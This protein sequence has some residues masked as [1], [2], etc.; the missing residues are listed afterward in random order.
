MK[1]VLNLAILA[2]T[3]A[4]FSCDSNDPAGTDPEPEIAEVRMLPDSVEIEVGDQMDFSL[5]ALTA[6]GDTVRNANLDV[7]WWS[8]DSTVFT[9]ENDGLATAQDTGSAWCMADVIELSKSAASLR[10]TGKDSAFVRVMLF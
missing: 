3:F 5:V 4:L 1:Y 9:V 6:T 7:T 8:T 2:V 10:F